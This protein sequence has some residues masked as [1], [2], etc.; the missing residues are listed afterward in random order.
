MTVSIDI[1]RKRGNTRR[2]VFNLLFEGNPVPLAGFSNFELTVSPALRPDDDTETLEVMMG[3]TINEF[4]GVFGFTPSG[5]ILPGN[6]YF[7]AVFK[8]DNNETFTFAEGT[9]KVTQGITK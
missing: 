6:Y 9:Y 1:E 2:I 5:N 4:D 8:D 3:Y 7:D